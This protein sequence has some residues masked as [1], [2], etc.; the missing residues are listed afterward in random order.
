MNL[1]DMIIHRILL[2]GELV[3]VGADKLTLL[4]PNVFPI[5]CRHIADVG[6]SLGAECQFLWGA[7]PPS[8]SLHPNRK[9]GFV[10]KRI[11]DNKGSEG[12]P[13]VCCG[14]TSHVFG[15]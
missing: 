9:N 4:I 1:L 15:M 5:G 3:A 10:P 12:I 6:G 2:L 7:R 14:H 11:H 13:S 8:K